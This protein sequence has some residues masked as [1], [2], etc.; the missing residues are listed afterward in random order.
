MFSW[1]APPSS[2]S[3]CRTR[4]VRRAD[5]GR[6]PGLEPGRDVGGEGGGRLR[7]GHGHAKNPPTSRSSSRATTI[8]CTSDAPSTSRAWR[9]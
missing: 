4:D 6:Q 9:A 5:R 3:L 2:R 8:R 7:P 1:M